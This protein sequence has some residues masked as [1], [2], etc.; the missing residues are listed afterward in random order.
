MAREISNS[1]APRFSFLYAARAPV[2]NVVDFFVLVGFADDWCVAVGSGD[3][4]D[5]FF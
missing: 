4:F 3:G 1:I 2:V 5:D